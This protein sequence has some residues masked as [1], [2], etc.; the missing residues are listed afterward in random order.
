MLNVCRHRGARIVDQPCGRLKRFVCPYHQWTYDLEGGL[1]AA[2]SMPNSKV[3]DYESL[4]MIRL[5][6]ETWQ[7]LVFGCL[8]DVCAGAAGRRGS[9]PGSAPSSPTTGR[10]ACADGTAHLH[11]RAPT[12]R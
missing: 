1:K 12:G 8:G 3:V 9:S 2:P 7:G 6:A 10:P 11:V 5:P 4:G